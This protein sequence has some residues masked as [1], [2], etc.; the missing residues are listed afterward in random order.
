MNFLLGMLGFL[1]FE[2]A[3]LYQKIRKGDRLLDVYVIP[4]VLVV[5]FMACF[6]GLMAMVMSD[7]MKSAVF[8][9]LTTPTLI[10]SIEKGKHAKDMMDD[11]A[12][13]RKIDDIEINGRPSFIRGMIGAF[14]R[15]FQ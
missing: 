7:G 14:S 9:G 10:Q 12:E 13:S 4:E 3:R 1:G 5:F 11:L 15:Y 8:I 2:A 6:S